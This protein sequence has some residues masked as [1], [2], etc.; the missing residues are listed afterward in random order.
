[1]SLPPKSEFGNENPGLQFG[2]NETGKFAKL[3]LNL[4]SMK[5]CIII[6]ELLF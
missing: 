2:S 4:I 5:Q 1:M 3:N 6:N